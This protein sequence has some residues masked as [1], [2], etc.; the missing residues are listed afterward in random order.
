MS[1]IINPNTSEKLLPKLV[2][3]TPYQVYLHQVKSALEPIRFRANGMEYLP[4]QLG[5]LTGQRKLIATAL[6]LETIDF[7]VN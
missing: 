3:M 4:P 2:A 7:E 1:R 6:V 5:G